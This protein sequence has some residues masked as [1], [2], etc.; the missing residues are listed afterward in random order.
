MVI[1]IHVKFIEI[2]LLV[3]FILIMIV[4]NAKK[5]LFSQIHQ[6]PILLVNV[7]HNSN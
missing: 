6:I 3:M 4:L 2:A 5:I 1:L 7:H